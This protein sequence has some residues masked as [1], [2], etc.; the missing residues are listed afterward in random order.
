MKITDKTLEKGGEMLGR[1]MQSYRT[2]IN[3]AYLKS[4][5]LNI[6]LS[7]KIEPGTTSEKVRL[8]AGINFVSERVKD[9]FTDQ[10]N[11]TPDLFEQV[12]SVMCPVKK[13]PVLNSYCNEKCK[14]RETSNPSEPNAA[15]QVCANF[16]SC[17]AWADHDTH[18]HIK[19]MLAWESP[20]KEKKRKAA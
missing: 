10:V 2:K 4:E 5:E 18:E 12:D 13:M 11:L 19:S 7:L 14:D 9:T 8:E 17:A 15:G 16:R 3:E 1:L 6:G 20:K